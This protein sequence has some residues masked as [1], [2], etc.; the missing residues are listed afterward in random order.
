MRL[1]Q[2]GA[3][4]AAL[5]G[6]LLAA[7]FPPV[8]WAWLA[9]VALVPLLYALWHEP[10]AWRR[11][12]NGW[13]AGFLFWLLVCHWIG[14][15]LDAYGGLSGWLSVVTLLLFALAKGLHLAVFSLAAGPMMRQVWA[16]PA[17][18]ALWAGLERTHGPLGF[19]WL[20]LGNAGIDMPLPLRLAPVTGV[21]G[22]SFLFAAIAVAATRMLLK[23]GRREALWLL[24]F[25]GMLFLPTPAAQPAKV[26]QAVSVQPVIR[27]GGPGWTEEEARR[28]IKDLSLLTLES[29]LDPKSPMAPS[30][31]LW[32]EAP[33][34]FYYYEDAAFR[35]QVSEVARLAGAPF[36]F[37]TVA[38]TPDRRP[39]NSAVV[40]NAKGR[41]AGRYDKMYLVPFGEF[42]PPLFSWIDKVSSE[43]GDFAAGRELGVFPLDQGTIGTFICYE[44]A[45]PHLVRR[46]AAQGAEVLV[47]LTNDGYFGRSAAR[48]QHLLLARMRAVENARYL[49]RSSNDGITASIHPTGRVLERA[50]EFK[51]M[52][53]R[54]TY[55]RQKRQTP[56]TRYGDWFAWGCLA[57][58]A[59]GGVALRFRTIN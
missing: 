32:P 31:L 11:F 18:A 21:Y 36:V 56:Y 20:N 1:W 51:R 5:T 2:L 57:V 12:L 9:P 53:L 22:L 19:A 38:F 52:A 43:A 4:G 37:T 34:P 15:T 58:G 24:P 14:E 47:N 55:Q 35:Q 48:P 46:F 42:V 30:L 45:F 39:L 10:S 8:S 13:L 41:L 7:L 33:A 26:E 40:L 59:A 17:V 44:S 50:P 6:L 27:A 29:A 28:T 54:M 23:Q 3:A 49:L 16:A 25:A